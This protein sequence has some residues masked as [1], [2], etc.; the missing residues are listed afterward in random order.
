MR[1]ALLRHPD[2]VEADRPQVH[3]DAAQL[4]EPAGKV[5]AAAR[6]LAEDVVRNTNLDR[7]VPIDQSDTSALDA[8]I[9]DFQVKAVKYVGEVI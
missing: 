4:A 2:Q 6:T 9:T 7:G 8:C 3:R 1:P 5:A